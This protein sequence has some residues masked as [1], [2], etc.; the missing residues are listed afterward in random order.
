M[1][2]IIHLSKVRYEQK[3]EDSARSRKDQLKNIMNS[4]NGNHIQVEIKPEYYASYNEILDPPK[5]NMFNVLENI[6][7][8]YQIISQYNWHAMTNSWYQ[9]NRSLTLYSKKSGI[10]ITRQEH[11]MTPNIP[12]ST[13][14]NQFISKVNV[15]IGTTSPSS[16]EHVRPSYINSYPAMNS[17]PN[18][19]GIEIN[20]TRPNIPISSNP[21]SPPSLTMP[22]VPIVDSTTH[23]RSKRKRDKD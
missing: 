7:Y 14:Q 16:V 18:P 11:Y 1:I 23:R 8:Q 13:P 10:E 4:I 12:P 21:I 19:N 9:N 6:F 20:A 2:P 15:I 5:L 17:F 3:L 22:S